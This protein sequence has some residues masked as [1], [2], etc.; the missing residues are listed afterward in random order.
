[1]LNKYIDLIFKKQYPRWT[2]MLFDFAAT[3]SIL[4]SYNIYQLD[5]FITISWFFVLIIPFV[6]FLFLRILGVYNTSIRYYSLENLFSL[7]FSFISSFFIIYQL[8]NFSVLLEKFTTIDL[9]IVYYLSISI[10]I[11]FRFFIK[12]I[13]KNFGTYKVENVLVVLYVFWLLLRGCISLDV[14]VSECL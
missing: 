8:S 3:A 5:N 7:V 9:L 6:N 14:C 4:L 11:S 12:I 10:I 2:I 13:F 1:M